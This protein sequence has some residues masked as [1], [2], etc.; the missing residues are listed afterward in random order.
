MYKLLPFTFSR[1]SHTEVLVN[2]VGDMLAA[3]EGTVQAI[4]ERSIDIKS[5]LY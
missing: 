5:E 3:P 4:V 1:I 2:E